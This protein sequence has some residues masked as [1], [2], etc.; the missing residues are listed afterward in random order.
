[1]LEEKRDE[2]TEMKHEEKGAVIEELRGKFSR[3]KVTILTECMG[4]PVNQVSELRKRLRSVQAEFR[5]VKNTMAARAVDGTA[6]SEAKAFFKGPLGVVIG[7]DDP[8]L[9]AKILRDFIQAEK[10]GEKMQIKLGLLEG[11]MLQP[12]QV[13][14]VATLPSR[15]IQLSIL[16]SGLQGP[17]RGLVSALSGILQNLVGVVHAIQE[18]RKEGGAEMATTEGKIARGDMTN[19]VKNMT[20]LELSEWVKEL[21]E[22]FG[23]T[24]A[25][26]VAVAAAPGGGA[27]A[28]AAE[29][30]DS[31]DVV[32]A[33]AAAD[34][35]IQVIKVVRELTSLGLKEAK[36]LVE[37]A[38]KPVK[39]GVSKEE[40]ATM[41]KKLEESGAKVEVK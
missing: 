14:A 23:V 20:V 28:P 9:P 21:E 40:A 10:R 38:P 33:S 37:G 34:K 26:P 22:T 35:K 5:V 4:L 19:A 39:T 12:P 16:L 36:D 15:E 13:A 17:T 29:E 31:F 7:Y 6:L 30:K 27:A 8:V 25:A 41:K 18:K 32:L 24:A 1:M 11:R 2:G 3:A